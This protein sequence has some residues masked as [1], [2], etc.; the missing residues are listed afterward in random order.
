MSKLRFK[1]LKDALTP[2]LQQLHESITIQ[3]AGTDG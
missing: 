1:N 2:Q 3:I